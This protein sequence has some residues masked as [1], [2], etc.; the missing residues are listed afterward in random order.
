MISE[1]AYGVIPLRR[2]KEKWEVFL[3]CHVKGNY[4]SF[5]KGHGEKVETPH[6]AAQRELFEET[7]LNVAQFL[8]V[9]SFVEDYDLLRN[10]VPAHKTVFYYLALVE[11]T[12]NLQENE[13]K[14]GK[15][16]DLSQ[17]KEVLT[18]S[19]SKEIFFQAC[20]IIAHLSLP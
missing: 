18:F 3:V 6:Q 12:V 14:E 7:G 1:K 4:W 17:A 19:G 15:W 20:K 16:F 11:G 10:G 8:D 13:I 5:P 9:S 2:E